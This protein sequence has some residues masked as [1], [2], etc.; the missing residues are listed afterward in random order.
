MSSILDALNK[1]ELEKELAREREN[2]NPADVDATSAAE[3]LIGRDVLRDKITMSINPVTLIGGG[4]LL[5]IIVVAVSVG[6]SVS[7]RPATP[8]AETLAAVTQGLPTPAIPLETAPAATPPAPE[9]GSS[10]PVAVPA[11]EPVAADPIEVVVEAPP[12]VVSAEVVAEALSETTSIQ[13]DRVAEVTAEVLETVEL[14]SR[15]VDEVVLEPVTPKSKV[16]EPKPV[17]VDPPMTAEP[18][19]EVPAPVAPK[20]EAPKLEVSKAE[21]P[22]IELPLVVEPKEEMPEVVLPESSERVEI[23]KADPVPITPPAVTR[24]SPEPER[25]IPDPEVK[26]P[27]AK[28]SVLDI[29]SLPPFSVGMQN[30]YGLDEFTINMINPKSDRNP[31]GSAIINRKKVY[32]GDEISG[33]QIRLH[34]VTDA[35]IAVEVS[36][37]GDLYFARF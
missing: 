24:F 35:G 13:T 25:R 3:D 2:V 14:M 23:A 9:T 4:L 5:V 18:K 11:A 7:L 20:A 31:Y 28:P 8:G 30:Q 26:V 17:I 1:L 34:V 36:R 10:I 15:H 22:V 32:E 12:T 27:A 37:T 16:D 6:V 33:S 29:R 19:A 21:V